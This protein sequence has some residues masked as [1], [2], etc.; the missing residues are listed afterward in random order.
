MP[1][2]DQPGQLW[3]LASE[4]ADEDPAGWGREL[5]LAEAAAVGLDDRLRG[6]RGAVVTVTAVTGTRL[7]GLLAEVLAD[8]VVV[9]H[10]AGDVVF[11]LAA[12][13]EVTAPLRPPRP[14]PTH[15]VGLLAWLRRYVGTAVVVGLRSGAADRR[16]GHLR[17]VGRDHLV[18]A[19]GPQRALVP[20][21][22]LAWVRVG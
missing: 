8:A 2:H 21:H 13:V 10:R 4:W 20:G 16:S 22:A 11:P 17:M 6:S 1:V 15:P 9:S 3:E 14:G 19:R 7:T 5:A 18:V 12:V